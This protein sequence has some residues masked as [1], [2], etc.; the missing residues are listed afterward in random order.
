[1]VAHAQR[2]DALVDAHA[3]RKEHKV[4]CLLV[5]GLDDELTLAERDVADL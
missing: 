5:D 1:M 2:E 3:R 4:G